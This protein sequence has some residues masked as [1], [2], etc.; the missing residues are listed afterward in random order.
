M[1]NLVLKSVI[2]LLV[3]T[4][5]G[6]LFAQQRPMRNNKNDQICKLLNLTEDQEKQ[7]QKFRLDH[8]EYVLDIKHKIEINQLEIKKILMEVNLDEAKL[9]SLSNANSELKAKIRDSKLKMWLDGYKILNADQQK[10][11]KKKFMQR[12]QRMALGNKAFR[13]GGKHKGMQRR[14][15]R[16]NCQFQ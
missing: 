3:V 7:M 10:L 15:N 11:W 13:K 1:K 5:A 6:S 12:G 2:F 9:L 14:M 4:F 16:N 8:Q